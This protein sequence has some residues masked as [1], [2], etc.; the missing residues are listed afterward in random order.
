MNRSALGQAAQSIAAA[1]VVGVLLLPST[2]SA[3]SIRECGSHGDTGNGR[4]GWTYGRILGAGTFNVTSRVVSCRTARRVARRSYPDRY[5]R[6]WSWRGWRC[7]ILASA[8]EYS[9]QRCTKRGGRVVRWQS[10]S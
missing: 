1:T 6:R 2:A 7:R 3:H 8:H 10:G 4:I 9:D 5:V